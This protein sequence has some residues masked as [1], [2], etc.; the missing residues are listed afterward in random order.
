[1]EP[2]LRVAACAY[3]CRCCLQA[4]VRASTDQVAPPT[5]DTC[6]AGI[7]QE[8]R[9]SAGAGSGGRCGASRPCLPACLPSR[10]PLTFPAD[11]PAV[12]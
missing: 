7:W 1:M 4:E 9:S 2:P 5:P 11:G 8:V 12:G 10:C 6:T 3:Y